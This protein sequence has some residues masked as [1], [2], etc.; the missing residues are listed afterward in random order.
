MCSYATDT[1]VTSNIMRY[2]DNQTPTTPRVPIVI[3][4]Y[5]VT[6]LDHCYTIQW[7]HYEEET[8]QADWP[9]Q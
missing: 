3:L 1:H 6:K 7:I 9:I 8:L 4:A 5:S 2:R